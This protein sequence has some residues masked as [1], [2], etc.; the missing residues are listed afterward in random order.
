[1]N[2]YLNVVGLY[3]GAIFVVALAGRYIRRWLAHREERH[4][5]L[6]SSRNV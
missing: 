2:D 3:A 6:K 1:M 5:P 4:V